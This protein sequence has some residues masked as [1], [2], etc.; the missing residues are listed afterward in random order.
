MPRKINK[1]GLF[2]SLMELS[3]PFSGRKG[4]GLTESA[5]EIQQLDWF[6]RL[7]K[8][9]KARNLGLRAFRVACPRPRVT[10]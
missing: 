10:A 9:R 3:G 1:T 7:A 2:P 4:K 6:S 8:R 5:T